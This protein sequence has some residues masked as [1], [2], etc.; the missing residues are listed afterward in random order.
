[1]EEKEYLLQEITHDY[2]AN[3]PIHDWQFKEISK[4]VRLYFKTDKDK[5]FGFCF[6]AVERVSHIHKENAKDWGK[7]C[8]TVQCIFRGW[9]T[10]DGVRHMN[11]GIENSKMYGYM[12][13]PDIETCAKVL[14]EIREME[15][16]YCNQPYYE[17]K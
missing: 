11:M 8:T 1:M 12:N 10:F 2:D 4:E 7:D 6:Y 5:G 16:K 3:K 13:Y 9:A 15:V 17:K 14:Q